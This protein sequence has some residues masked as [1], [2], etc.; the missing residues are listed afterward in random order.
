M[1]R[2]TI[3]QVKEKISKI[4]PDLELDD[5]TYK[6]VTTKCRFVDKKYGEFWC[7]PG[8]IISGKQKGHRDGSLDRARL[9]SLGKYGTESPNQSKDVRARTEKTN[10]ER[11]GSKTPGESEIVKAKAKKTNMERYGVEHAMQYKGSKDKAIQ[12]NLERY[13]V[14]NPLQNREIFEKMQK[15]NQERY[16]VNSTLQLEDVKNKIKN[17][18]LER[19]GS[20]N[21][22]G[23][24]EIKER[25]SNTLMEKYGTNKIHEV[26]EIMEKRIAAYTNREPSGGER[27]LKEWL[28]SQGF[29]VIKRYMGGNKPMEIDIFI[30]DKMFAI[31][32]NGDYWHSEANKAIHKNYHRNKTARAA[33]LGIDL[34][35]IFES[36]WKT[37]KDICK[38]FILA[39][40]GMSRKVFARNCE[41][42]GVEGHIANQ[43]FKENHLQG[44]A[45]LIKAIGLFH[46]GELVSCIGFS[47]PHRQNMGDITH[48][49]RF[50]S[51][52]GVSVVGGLSRMCSHASKDLGEFVS[53]VHLRLSNGESYKKAG[54]ELV[55]EVAPDYWYFDSKKKKIVSK[56]S[57][58][59]SKVKT[60]TDMTE[61]EHA[62]KEGLFRIYDCGKL[63]FAYKPS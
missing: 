59:K 13:G 22:F 3:E 31:E 29:V 21:P 7:R 44:K 12:T 9:T 18:N 27:E 47:K 63:K 53:F 24:A 36:E 55:S 43:F 49:S 56:Q 42:R 26:P 6:N 14:K 39:K 40:L 32:Y 33:E 1:K 10:L 25:I 20:E 19:Y 52:G 35:H 58:R 8:E 50:A 23:S 41:V 17:T 51:K 2:L 54:F 15:T 37:K 5:T 57:R 45:K 48:L 46:E 28:E 34:I 4:N 60:P 62:L 11:Y 38:D 61:H 30:E 16:G